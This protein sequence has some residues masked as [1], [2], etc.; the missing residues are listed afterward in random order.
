MLLMSERCLGWISISIETR[1]YLEA[2]LRWNQSARHAMVMVMV[3]KRL[4]ASMQS[5]MCKDGIRLSHPQLITPAYVGKISSREQSSIHYRRYMGI[6]MERHQSAGWTQQPVEDGCTTDIGIL[7]GNNPRYNHK[8]LQ[9]DLIII[10]LYVSTNIEN[11]TRQAE[12]YLTD[13]VE[14]KIDEYRGSFSASYSFPPLATL[15]GIDALIK[16]L[17]TQLTEEIEITRLRR[18]FSSVLKWPLSFRARH[19]LFKKGASLVHNKD[20][21]TQEAIPNCNNKTRRR[22]RE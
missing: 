22:G 18:Q 6:I 21:H 12:K 15:P 10:N 8:E 20:A 9:F 7:F 4:S 13:A 1:L 3:G 16:D 5:I 14:R 2:L 17:V 11:A 19:H